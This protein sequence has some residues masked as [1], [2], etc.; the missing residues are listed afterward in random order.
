MWDNLAGVCARQAAESTPASA[1]RAVPDGDAQDEPEEPASAPPDAR[2]APYVAKNPNGLIAKSWDD[3]ATRAKR[4]TRDHVEVL[5]NGCGQPREFQSMAKVF[6]EFGIP[7]THLPDVRANVKKMYQRFVNG[8]CES[9]FMALEH[10][11]NM[12]VFRI[13]KKERT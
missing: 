6:A 13:V 12:F 4:T 8:E 3:P 1:R 11:G 9:E 7:K 2:R 10:R 5:I